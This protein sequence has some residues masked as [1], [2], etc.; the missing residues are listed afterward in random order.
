MLTK[1]Q[2]ALLGAEEIASFQE[3]GYAV[4]RGLLGRQELTT[5]QRA[6]QQA[7]ATFPQSPN[8]YDVTAAADMFWQ[9][10]AANDNQGSQQHDL[11]ALAAAVRD[12]PFPRLVDRERTG[13]RGRFLL[14]TGV[15][16]RVSLLGDFAR[17]S[18]LPELASSLL[19]APRVRYY[20]D[21]LFVK[22]PGA[23][24]RAAFHQDLPYFHLDGTAGCVFWVPLGR[25][26]EGGGRMGYIP[27]SHRW[28]MFKPNVFVSALPFP[29]SEGADMPAIDE[30]PER[31]GVRYVD[32]EPGDVIVHHFLTVHGSEGNR[33]GHGRAAFSLR[34]CDAGMRYRYRPGAPQQPLHRPN[35]DDGDELDAEIHPIVWP[36]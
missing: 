6:M 31:F 15:W 12:S 13:Q 8:S 34:Y 9:T 17:N 5:L 16:R 19:H 18:V 35:M 10:D 33:T 2:Q 28:G 29:G 24:D 3:Q 7:L 1:L 30:A 4:L 20:D 14:D 26:R 32:I 23:V 25:V 21:Q 22:E 27:G 36:R 11:N